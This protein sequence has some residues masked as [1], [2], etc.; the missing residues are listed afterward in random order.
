[1]EDLVHIYTA[2]DKIIANLIKGFLESNKIR[3]LIKANPGPEG[4]FLGR[5]GGSAPFNPWLVYVKKDNVQEAKKLLDGFNKK[6]EFSDEETSSIRKVP[7]VVKIIIAVLLLWLLLSL[8]L[9][10]IDIFKYFLS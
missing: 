3:V 6:N 10:F 2:R 5:F 7:L 8:I 4:V 1:M 9:G